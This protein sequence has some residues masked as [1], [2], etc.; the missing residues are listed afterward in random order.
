MNG[1]KTDVLVSASAH[2]HRRYGD[3]EIEID[4]SNDTIK[5]VVCEI[6]LGASLSNNF[7]WN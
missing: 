7:Q 5:P 2:E 3:F 1:D 4:T 6:L